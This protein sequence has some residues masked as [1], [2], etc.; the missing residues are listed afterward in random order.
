VRKHFYPFE[1][2][3]RRFSGRVD[4]EDVMMATHWST[5][6]LAESVRSLIGE[7]MYFVQDFEPAFYPMGSEYILAENTYRKNLYAITS[8]PW[9]AHM[10]KRDYAMEADSFRFP[11]DGTIYNVGAAGDTPRAKRVLFFAKPEMARRCFLIGTMA[12]KE[13]HRIK[14]DYEI[15]FFGSGSAKQ[16]P[17]DYPVT[18]LD[19]VPTLNDLANLYATSAAGLVFSTTNPSLVPYEMMACGLPV[20]DLN[21]PGNEVNYDNRYDIALLADA[22]PVRMAKDMAALLDDAEELA[23]RSA[24][25]IEFAA[26]FPS[27]EEMARRVEKLI[28]DRLAQNKPAQAQASAL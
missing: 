18:Y 4:G 5:V 25:G 1:G 27:E 10:L 24:R 7:I 2:P 12:L 23:T 19:I 22:D 3:V 15:L 21:R 17:Q 13:F 9:C 16:H 8:G 20:V 11:V 6:A 14:P 28:L 26:T